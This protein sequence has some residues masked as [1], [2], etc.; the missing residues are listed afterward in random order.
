MSPA[1]TVKMRHV[2]GFNPDVGTGESGRRG[3]GHD[4][5]VRLIVG[6][7][8]AVDID[9]VARDLPVLGRGRTAGEA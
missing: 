7:R 9:P 1:S 4:R 2:A 5:R 8:P 3:H 6:D